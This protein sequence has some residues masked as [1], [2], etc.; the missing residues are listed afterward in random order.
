MNAHPFDADYY[1]RSARIVA[2]DLLGARLV[3]ILPDGTR[4][5]RF[6]EIFRI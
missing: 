3:R 6:S 1:A 4:I 5:A 2:R